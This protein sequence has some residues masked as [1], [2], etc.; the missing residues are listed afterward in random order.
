MSLRDELPVNTGVSFCS[1]KEF[2]NSC[3]AHQ[4]A[5]FVK[6]GGKIEIVPAGVGKDTIAF[7]KGADNK[8][9]G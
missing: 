3:I 7:N 1:V 5:N 2:E 6:A 4:V 9:T 8:K